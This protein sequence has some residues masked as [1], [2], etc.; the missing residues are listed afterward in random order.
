MATPGWLRDRMS[1]QN[2]AAITAA[3]KQRVV[4]ELYRQYQ[5]ASPHPMEDG[6]P[7]ERRLAYNR[8][9]NVCYRLGVANPADDPQAARE[10]V[11]TARI[12]SVIANVLR[13]LSDTAAAR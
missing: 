6:K 8:L 5:E 4:N 11:R 3:E 7:S 13:D 10:S 12:D 1:D 2:G 9:G